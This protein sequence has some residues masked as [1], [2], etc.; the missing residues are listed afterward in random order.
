MPCMH[1]FISE[2]VAVCPCSIVCLLLQVAL[3]CLLFGSTPSMVLMSG[4]TH[5]TTAYPLEY[6][7]EASNINALYLDHKYI[8]AY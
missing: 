2:N 7:T 8:H 5:I 1:T 3:P 6:M 4:V